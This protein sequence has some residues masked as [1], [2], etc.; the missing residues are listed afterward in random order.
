MISNIVDWSRRTNKCLHQSIIIFYISSN[1]TLWSSIEVATQRYRRIAQSCRQF[2]K[3]ST[4]LPRWRWTQCSLWN[5]IPNLRESIFFEAK[6]SWHFGTNKNQVIFH[7]F[8]RRQKLFVVID[9]IEWIWWKFGWGNA[10]FRQAIAIREKQSDAV[11]C[12]RLLFLA[13]EKYFQV[14]I[15]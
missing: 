8:M 7:F 3:K 10:F 12:K 1:Q 6:L 9:L 5:N 13:A 14:R 11:E 15:R 2:R 4:D